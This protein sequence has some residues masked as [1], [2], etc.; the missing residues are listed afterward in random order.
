MI[1]S[2][3]MAAGLACVDLP[4]MDE[5][6]DSETID[7]AAVISLIEQQP[8]CAQAHVV[9]GRLLMKKQEVD[10]GIDAFTTG[11][12]SQPENS[13]LLT[14]QARALLSRASRDSSLSDA[15]AAVA[16]LEKAIEIDAMNLDARETLAAFH[17]SA[18]WIAGGDMDVAEEQAEFVT[19]HDPQRGMD[20]RI[21]N[22]MAD[23]DED[24]A[25]E[26]MKE[27]LA[28]QPERDEMAVQLAVAYH[29]EGDYSNAFSV[30][31]EYA[32]KDEP[33]PMV[34]YQLGRTAALSGDFLDAGRAAMQRYIAMAESDESPGIPASSAY[35]R[36]GN[37]E[38]HAGDIDAAR[39]AYERSLALDPE[40]EQARES[41]DH[42]N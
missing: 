2:M 6:F 28:K 34:V 22:L 25:I 19:Q 30:L 32:E 26:L 41:L 39:D 8:D 20:M 5:N 7:H 11:V 14:W 23:G 16:A 12:E 15:R 40:N 17:R 38:E 33:N 29:G 3:M 13:M 9:H 37:I 31:S 18:P 27:V 24:E 10:A 36:L 4:A 21:S 42:L 1:F 35:W